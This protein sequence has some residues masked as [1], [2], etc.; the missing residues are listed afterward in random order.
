MTFLF[1]SLR[2]KSNDRKEGLW[3]RGF[4]GTSLIILPGAHSSVISGHK[5]NINNNKQKEGGKKNQ[6]KSTTVKK[7]KKVRLT[8]ASPDIV[9]IESKS[10][11]RQE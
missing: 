11:F 10:V 1:L 5:D 7:K 9:G 6:T 8:E 4:V 3:K 2:I